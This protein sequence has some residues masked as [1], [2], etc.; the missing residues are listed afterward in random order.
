MPVLPGFKSTVKNILNHNNNWI[1][2]FQK[3]KHRYTEWQ[4]E[5]VE[6][7]LACGQ[8]Y[9]A[10]TV[11][12]C[13][14]C[15]D[16][17]TVPFTC[18]GRSCSRC[19]KIYA[20][21]WGQQFAE[22]CYKVK[23]RHFILTLP[24]E[25]YPLIQQDR[26]WKLQDAMLKAAAIAMK[27]LVKERI[28]DFIPGMVA[29]IHVIGR[30]L[31]Y[32]PHI[33]IIVTAGGLNKNGLWK[34]IDF[35]PYVRLRRLWQQEV[36]AH[37]QDI[38]SEADSQTETLLARMERYNLGSR[39]GFVIKDVEPDGIQ[40]ENLKGLARYLARYLRHPPIGDS[41]IIGYS[42]D[43]VL[44]TWEWGGK[45]EDGEVPVDRVIEAL[46]ENVPPKS[47]QASRWTGIY[48]NKLYPWAS[49]IMEHHDRTFPVKKGK[50]GTQKTLFPGPD[51][52]KC[53]LPMRL[54]YG[55]Y[56]PRTGVVKRYDFRGGNLLS[57]TG[58]QQLLDDLDSLS[59]DE[60][61]EMMKA[62]CA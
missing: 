46:L 58:A 2:F 15:G 31:N 26:E 56:T 1:K 50:A 48:S 55:F 28:G 9:R 43:E 54:L 33:H 37:F 18:H 30:R 17:V 21:R 44:I 11:F 10:K 7:L 35:F 61:D 39:P 8:T 60:E 20:D 38:L 34:D 12:G 49:T 51:C 32:N 23:H 16:T 25:L 3:N 42:G 47:F 22:K 52:N 29:V 36:M 53:N 41:R 6:D 45:W 59:W 5:A 14:G 27:K 13:D 4:L 62:M 24:Q 40:V 57:S 19:G